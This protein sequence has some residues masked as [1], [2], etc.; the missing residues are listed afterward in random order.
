MLNLYFLGTFHVIFSDGYE[1]AITTA[2]AKSLL[3]YLV[4]ENDRPHRREQLAAMFWPEADQK[5][6]TQSLRQALYALRRQ[7]QPMFT[8]SSSEDSPYLTVTRQDVAFNFDSAHW[9]DIGLFKALLSATQQ[10]VHHSLKMCPTCIACLQ[11]AVGLYKGEFLA[12]LTLPD[13]EGFEEWRNTRREDFRAQVIRSLLAIADFYERRRDYNQARQYLMRLVEIEPWNEESHRRIMRLLALDGQRS[14]AIQQFERARRLLMQELGVEPSSETFQ[15]AQQIQD[16][17]VLESVAESDMPYKGLYPF[18]LA[19][20]T[21]F[22]GR[23]EAVHYV[24]QQ[25]ER[26]P[27]VFVV[28]SSGSGKSSLIQAGVLPVLLSIRQMPAATGHTASAPH[29]LWAIVEFRPGADLFRSCAEALKKLSNVKN[30]LAELMQQLSGENALDYVRT[31]LPKRKHTLLFVDQFEELFTLCES[32]AVRRAF[33]DLLLH[34]AHAGDG[35]PRVSL[36]ASMRAD[37]IGQALSHRPFAEALQRG[38]VVLGPMG[39]DELRRAIEEPARNRGVVF[40]AGLVNRLLDDVGEEPGNL[41]LLQFA[42]AELWVRREGWQISHDAYDAIGRV[43]GALASYADQVFARLDAAEQALARRLFVQLVQPGDETGDTRRP[44]LRS[45]LGEPAWS[46]ARKLAD[47]RLVVT[48]RSENEESVEIVH[49]ALIRNWS[50]LRE[51]MD[52][53]RDFRRWQQRLRTFLLHWQA[54]GREEE[55]LLRGLS[56]SEAARWIDARRTELSEIEQTFIDASLEAHARRQAEIERIRQ[57]ELE[58]AQQLA[59]IEH[60]RAEI[61]QTTNRRLRWLT[62]AL[63]LVLVVAVSAAI[64]AASSRQEAQRFAQQA[65]ARQLVAQSLIYADSSTDLALLLNVEALVRITGQEERVTLLN[66]FPINP[67]LERYFWGGDGDIIN[68]I[69]TPDGSRL[70]TVEMNGAESSVRLWDAASGRATGTLL[71]PFAYSAVTVAPSG[72]YVATA[73]GAQIHLWNGVDASV[74][75]EVSVRIAATDTIRALQFTVDAGLLMAKTVNGEILFL[76]TTS[77][78]E[79]SR[80]SIPDGAE[81]TTLSPDASLLAVTQ[82]VGE[83]RG[84]NLWRTDTGELTGV[85]LGGHTANITSVTF[86]TDGK[87]AVT[88]SFDGT[89]RLW[90]T[91]SGELLF[92][93]LN[94]HA[95]RVLSSALSPDERT[96]ATGGADHHI[97]LYDLVSRRMIGSALIGH[98]NWVRSLRFT[99]RGDMLYSGTIAGGLVQWNL[100]RR[101]LLEGHTGRVRAVALS[102][103]GSTLATASFDRRVLLWDAEQ[104]RQI[105]EFLSPFENSL[106]QVAFSPDGRYVAAG[107]GGGRAMLWERESGEL[108]HIWKDEDGS[109]AIALAFSPDSRTLAVGHFSGDVPLWDVVT[110]ALVSA[111]TRT[112]AGWALSLVFSP[113]G[114]MLATGGQEGRIKLWDVDPSR[115]A[116]DRPLT[117]IGEALEGHTYWVTSLLWSNDGKTLISGSADNTVRFWD[118]QKQQPAA[119]PIKFET[120]IWGVQ[121]YPPH[122]E[123]SLMILGNNGNVFLWDLTMYEPLMPPQETHLETESFVVSPR[124]DAVFL[125]SIDERVEKW[126][127]DSRPWLQRSCDIAARALSQ[128]EW[129]RYLG[130]LP[131]NPVCTS[132]PSP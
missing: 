95:G 17:R 64:L 94:D 29:E 112:H 79:R 81:A 72:A 102:T 61:E 44:T 76:D 125:A 101:R 16:G 54:S 73:D 126:Q 51:W 39:R 97:Y 62:A 127:F 35:A 40:E 85:R 114:S 52:E 66:T 65:F 42:L 47:L 132:T 32:P 123:Q 78:Q 77:L 12:G 83:E 124:G 128:L 88:T 119:A 21:D 49:E 103:D 19:D 34:L 9:S 120:Q 2:K 99:H 100:A 71:P 11:E 115:L 23:E 10:H 31:L 4:T 28:G 80:F 98:N 75:G 33:I 129:E 116:A 18:S 7:L 111:H 63:A 122:G 27:V 87:R 3:A 37:F 25:L 92:G 8:E 110:G 67:F 45:E 74:L 96:L 58:K 113:D 46:L 6:A 86:T 20:S 90:D 5:S 41:P 26:Q 107:D 13:A 14:A 117:A 106:L 59:E 56:L 57:Q 108:R 43:A 60:R 70:L 30:D 38:G 69:V 82:D 130:G 36:L 121:F 104:G 93:P 105:A 131:Y 89:A 68:I 24:L 55:A 84:V 15:L 1:P 109:V 91:Q 22:H 53:D 118:V 48:G 50:K